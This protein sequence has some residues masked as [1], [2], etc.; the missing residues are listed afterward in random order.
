M[1]RWVWSRSCLRCQ[2]G[3]SEAG[4][5]PVRGV[6]KPSAQRLTISHRAQTLCLCYTVDSGGLGEENC[7]S[8]EEIMPTTCSVLAPDDHRLVHELL[9]AAGV[10]TSVGQRLRLI[11]ARLLGAP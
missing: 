2:G 7:S 5:S 3:V 8:G 4:T 9:A 11:T 6:V 10:C 1:A